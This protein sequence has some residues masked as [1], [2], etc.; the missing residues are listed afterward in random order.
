MRPKQIKHI[1]F[2]EMLDTLKDRRTLISMIVIPILVI[3]VLMF[4]IGALISS[5]IQKA[6]QKTKRLAIFGQENAPRLT[7]HILAQGKFTELNLARDSL[8]QALQDKRLEV[9]LE[10]PP[11]FEADLQNGDTA[12]VV[13]SYDQ[14]EV[15]SELAQDQL[16]EIIRQFE[17]E[18]VEAKLKAVNL[19]KESI[20][21]IK[22]TSRNLAPQEKMSGFF[23]SMFLP[24]LLMILCLTGAMYPAMDL[25]AGEKE[26]GTLETLLVTPASRLDI[27][28]GKFLAVL[29]ASFVTGVL[30]TASLTLASFL[31]M[32]RLD[33]TSQAASLSLSINPLS[34]VLVV[35]LII[36]MA[37]LFSALLLSLS[38]V[39]RS[40]KEAQS[41]VSPLM[42]L[43]IFPAM[44]SFIPG[45]EFQTIHTL[46]PVLNTSLV[47]KDVLLGTFEWGKIGLVFL[48]N[49][50]YAA[51]GVFVSKQM[52]E[53]ES[54]LF[55]V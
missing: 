50:G 33:N 49:T 46:I 48:V 15:K 51:F 4:G 41:Y 34:F 23:L 29:T 42:I 17:E 9:A 10:I 11:N 18:I 47:L 32:L 22:I 2:K 44:V 13:I 14:A 52:F 1:Y 40:Y 27:A 38:L 35:L 25:T 37:C 53:K 6:E 28:A 39:A 43:V 12:G 31:G 54:V 19:N 30:A 36:P 8:E 55:R 45:F 7:E 16:K 3:P 5:Q 26:R 20:S 21:P 24:Y